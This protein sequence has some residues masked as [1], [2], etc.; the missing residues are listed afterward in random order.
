LWSEASM[1]E[2]IIALD[3]VEKQFR[4]APG[5]VLSRRR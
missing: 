1:N 3:E 4:D 5:D 2:P